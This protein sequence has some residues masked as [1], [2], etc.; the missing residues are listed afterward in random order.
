MML[1]DNSGCQ[2]KPETVLALEPGHIH[3]ALITSGKLGDA[4]ISLVIA[5]NLARVGFVVT[6]CNDFVHSLAD[7][8]PALFTR[9][10]FGPN[11]YPDG[12]S[13]FD[14]VLV[15]AQS[16]NLPAEGSNLRRELASRA[17]FFGLSHFDASLNGRFDRTLFPADR[18]E[19][20][21]SLLVG[22]GLARN[23]AEK[24]RSMVE[25]VCAFC[26]RELNLKNVTQ[27]IG[28]V[29]PVGIS[30]M[31]DPDRIII[32][33]T[34]GKARKNWLATR[35]LEL[36]T[37]LKAKGKEPVFT[38]APS[39]RADWRRQLGNKFELAKTDSASEL[40]ALLVSASAVVCND[41]GVGHLAGA[42]G[43]PVL[44]IIS[45]RDPFYTWRPGWGAVTL[46]RPALPIRAL[47][48][49]WPYLVSV[50]AVLR[51]LDVLLEKTTT[52]NQEG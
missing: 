5:N 27:E 29:A 3:I 38:A 50:T 15:D 46:V 1:S 41:S 30:T 6:V 51:R 19:L 48:Q 11:E 26:R 36:A 31:P 21:G 40:A 14:L 45:R 49:V 23:R 12:F 10:E 52:P 44:C 34:S 13:N 22:N 33:P 18:R 4:L 9:P 25:H 8:L 28:L 7:W 32:C 35:F 39:E 16:P 37:Q 47:P 42:L 20:L 17:V 2:D 24:G 43:T